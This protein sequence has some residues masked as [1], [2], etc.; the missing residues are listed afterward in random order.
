CDLKILLPHAAGDDRIAAARSA[1]EDQEGSLRESLSS[2]IVFVVAG[3]GGGAGTGAAPVVAR[4]ARAN[5]AVTIGGAI[6]PF[7]TE[8]RAETARPGLEALPRGADSVIVVEQDS[9]PQP[10]PTREGFGRPR[11][12]AAA[13][14]SRPLYSVRSG[15][16]AATDDALRRT[17]AGK[18]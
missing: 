13:R 12:E 17:H 11:R 4:A 18:F 2:D 5:G 15:G 9:C 16:I 10:T 8:A 7:E 3:L 1:A 6:L 14:P